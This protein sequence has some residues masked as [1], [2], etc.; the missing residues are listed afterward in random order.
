MATEKLTTGYRELDQ[1]LERLDKACELYEQGLPIERRAKIL[2]RIKEKQECL[3]ILEDWQNKA[4]KL[5]RAQAEKECQ[6]IIDFIK[7][8]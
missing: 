4:R 5:E 8:S 2:E 6:K 7:E 3:N 1:S